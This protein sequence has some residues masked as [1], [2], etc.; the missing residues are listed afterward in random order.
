LFYYSQVYTYTHQLPQMGKMEFVRKLGIR[1][2]N[3]PCVCP[4]FEL[5]PPF[6]GR[7]G[8]IRGVRCG[9]AIDK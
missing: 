7:E 6:P 2:G 9:V 1:R 3:A 8:E 4:I 5:F